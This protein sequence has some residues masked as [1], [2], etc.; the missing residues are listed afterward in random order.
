M[1]VFKFEVT[2]QDHR[3]LANFLKSKGFSKKAILTARHHG[4]LILVNQ[5]RRMTNFRLKKG[6]VVH[7]VAGEEKHNPYLKANNAPLEVVYETDNYVIINKPAGLLTIPSRY[8]DDDSV[9]NRL[10]HYLPNQKPHVI[11]RL[12]RDTSGLVLVGK[13]AICHA[14][15]S[16]HN[17]TKKYHAVVHGIFDQKTGLI[18]A[19]IAKEGDGVKRVVRVDGKASQTKYRVIATAKDAS[20]VELSLL[21]GRTHQIRVHMSYLGHP[22]FGDVLYGGQDTFQRQALHCFYLAFTDPF[23]KK[24]VKIAIPDASDMVSLC[25]ELKI[26]QAD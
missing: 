22:L 10:L 5:K 11:T 8:E 16:K 24:D 1:Q 20:L 21:T 18:D 15:F 23:T 19:P 25:Q 4:G 13:T 9:V 7:F 12:D 17:F 6:D 26:S 14:R 3:Q 2:E